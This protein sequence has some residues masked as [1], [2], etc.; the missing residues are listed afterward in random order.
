MD[1]PPV[2]VI[3][4]VP[5]IETLSKSKTAIA[6]GGP[7]NSNCGCN[8]PIVDVSPGPP[9]VTVNESVSNETV[10]EVTE[11]MP[12]DAYAIGSRCARQTDSL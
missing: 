5:V 4:A 1:R 12:S 9:P 7:P 3:V 11:R 2:M 6:T 8:A 10:P